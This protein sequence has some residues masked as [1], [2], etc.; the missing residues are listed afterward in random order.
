MV[1]A[2]LLLLLAFRLHSS[3]AALFVI[4]EASHMQSQLHRHMGTCYANNVYMLWQAANVTQWLQSPEWHKLGWLCA[5][6]TDDDCDCHCRQIM[7]LSI[8]GTNL[9]FAAK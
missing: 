9:S 5:A 2:P 4:I 3:Q 7:Q 6:A 8:Y 1:A